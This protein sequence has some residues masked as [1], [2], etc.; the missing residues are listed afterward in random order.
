MR[1]KEGL[2]YAASSGVAMYC[3]NQGLCG[4]L[5]KG[6]VDF[7]DHFFSFL[8]GFWSADSRWQSDFLLFEE[9]LCHDLYQGIFGQYGETDAS[10]TCQASSASGIWRRLVSPG[11]FLRAHMLTSLIW[12][13]RVQNDEPKSKF[14]I[15]WSLPSLRRQDQ[16]HFD[17]VLLLPVSSVLNFQF[18]PLGSIISR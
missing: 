2:F 16:H 11:T 12:C 8:Q 13:F 6:K 1:T 10:A 17:S 5:V 18:S 7:W 14:P 9:M 15:Q 3:G 4:S